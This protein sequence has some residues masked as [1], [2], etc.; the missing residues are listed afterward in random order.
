MADE[1]TKPTGKPH[2]G[3]RPPGEPARTTSASSHAEASEN[4]ATSNRKSRRKSRAESKGE[5]SDTSEAASVAGQAGEV[6]NSPQESS[7]A[8]DS[9]MPGLDQAIKDLD[10]WVERENVADDPGVR[11]LRHD[12]KARENLTMWAATDLDGVLPPA[13][14][15][16]LAAIT[17]LKD[18]LLFTR[19][20]G[21]F[22]PIAVTWYAISR[23]TRS[24][25][26]FADNLPPD[27]EL[28][29]VRYWQAGGEGLFP[30][31]DMPPD[32]IL[33]SIYRLSHVAWIDAMIIVGL[34]LLTALARL[35]EWQAQR[36]R[37][38]KLETA[39]NE[40]VDVVLGLQ[41]ALYGFRDAT[42][43]SI[44]ESLAESLSSLLEAAHG[45]SA[46]A[47]E[48]QRATVGITELGPS[49][50]RFATQLESAEQTFSVEL[51]P[52][53]RDLSA[54]VR[55]LNGKLGDDYKRSVDTA[56]EGLQ[57]VYQQL[58]RTGASVEVGTKALLQD[59]EAILAK[60]GVQRR[61]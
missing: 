28:N 13:R 35:L 30:N 20:I 42:P 43:T 17:S 61:Q 22:V 59:I 38:A 14:V 15:P 3:P 26:V 7:A 55:G 54:I 37:R 16:R 9:S 47:K 25:A 10:L 46:T 44:S 51:T 19:N 53:V 49:I 39:D 34:I 8:S 1:P 40:R 21:I 31:I 32:A 12:L 2:P 5:S 56:L 23:A 36:I 45:L 4:G 18:L 29:F 24:F 11:R 33:A 52:S 48:L 6:S 58:A 27:A 41:S 60:T 57:E 50:E